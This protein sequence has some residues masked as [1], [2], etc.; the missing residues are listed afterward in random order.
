MRYRYALY[1]VQTNRVV[2]ITIDLIRRLIYLKIKFLLSDGLSVQQCENTCNVPT[3]RYCYYLL[4][5]VQG[6]SKLRSNSYSDGPYNEFFRE[7]TDSVNKIANQMKLKLNEGDIHIEKYVETLKETVG[8]A[9]ALFQ[10]SWIMV[11]FRFLRLHKHKQGVGL[12]T[13][14]WFF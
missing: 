4:Q 6:R 9:D 3:Y 14:T 5:Q 7:V 2:K 10:E 13:K 12:V 11:S 1:F 8:R